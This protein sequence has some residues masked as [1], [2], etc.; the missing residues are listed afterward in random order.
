MVAIYLEQLKRFSQRDKEEEN[1][2]GS[3]DNSGRKKKKY[4]IE[5]E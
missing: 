5:T 1:Y 2:N 4:Y 3:T